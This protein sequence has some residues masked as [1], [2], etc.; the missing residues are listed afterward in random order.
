[1]STS[2]SSDMD[3]TQ[4]NIQDLINRI[5]ALQQQEDDT[6]KNLLSQQ[7]ASG[8]D[9]YTIGAMGAFCAT[10]Y[11]ETKPCCGVEEYLDNN[12]YDQNY[13]PCPADKPQC[14]GYE[15]GV[16]LGRCIDPTALGSGFDSYSEQLMNE[17]NNIAEE[18]ADLYKSL[19]NIY[20]NVQ[21][22]VSETRSDLVDQITVIGIVQDELENARV[23]LNQLAGAKNNKNRMA[24]INTYYGKKYH[25]HTGIMKMIIL[26]CVPLLILA[27]LGKKG[28]VG[29]SITRPLALLVILI[30]G[31][32]LIR[33]LWDL[34]SRD[35]MNY[36]EYNWDFDPDNM[37]PTVYEYDKQQYDKSNLQNDI[38]TDLHRLSS[39]LGIE[40]IGPNCCGEGMTYDND[41]NKCISK[42]VETFTNMLVGKDSNINKDKIKAYPTLRPQ[43]STSYISSSNCN[44]NGIQSIVKPYNNDDEKYTNI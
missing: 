1:M 4:Q 26:I 32:F 21:R 30:G 7:K 37:Q 27:I 15:P 17:I 25:A 3:N 14:A 43:Q 42:D 8:S 33:R 44:N 9:G 40:C 13:P 20:G 29:N 18:R 31:F 24:Q 38:K 16:T 12:G 19:L 23:N 34:Y 2:S 11:N 5:Q 6:V 41:T 10:N 22:D 36:D 28:I 35:N 39:D